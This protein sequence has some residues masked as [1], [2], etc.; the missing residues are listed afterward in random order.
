MRTELGGK[1]KSCCS[2]FCSSLLCSAPLQTNRLYY[3]IVIYHF[4][5]LH[6]DNFRKIS[7]LTDLCVS[8][9]ECVC[10]PRCQVPSVPLYRSIQNHTSFN[11]S[12]LGIFNPKIFNCFTCIRQTWRKSIYKS[13]EIQYFDSINSR[14]NNESEFGRKRLELITWMK[15]MNGYS[16]TEWYG[17]APNGAIFTIYSGS[18]FFRKISEFPVGNFT[19]FAI[20]Q[21]LWWAF[22]I[23]Q[24][25]WTL[26][27]K[28]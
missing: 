20:W 11:L 17:Y 3:V 10:I 15:H 1:E 21:I 23:H 24:I 13:S 26:V 27:R 2:L 12:V 14:L 5:W 7:Q 28:C 19:T 9:F 25:K 18:Q 16:L 6:D 8:V 4:T 22:K